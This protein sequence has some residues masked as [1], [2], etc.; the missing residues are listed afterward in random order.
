MSKNKPEKNSSNDF[1]KS[2]AESFRLN[3]F[4]RELWI[5]IIIGTVNGV[6]SSIIVQAISK[7]LDFG[8]FT[9]YA[10]LIGLVIVIFLF[11]IPNL[12]GKLRTNNQIVVAL[13]LGIGIITTVDYKSKTDNSRFPF[14]ETY[15][16]WK[17]NI[18]EGE[19]AVKHLYISG[20]KSIRGNS[21]LAFEVHLQY[22]PENPDNAS[23]IYVDLR[24][25]KR[26][27]EHM[28]DGVN[29]EN[30]TITC[31]VYI[32]DDFPIDRRPEEHPHVIRLFLRDKNQKSYYG[33]PQ[34]I[35]LQGSWLALGLVN[36]NPPPQEIRDEVEIDLN[37]DPSKI[38][39]LGV[40]VSVDTS[41]HINYDGTLY[42]DAVH[43]D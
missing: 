43:W 23:S 22:P 5:N 40:K 25:D 1:P 19:G 14:E 35:D 24:R 8:L 4:K 36:K 42:L 13:V 3:L 33:V 37:F 18:K 27:A 9:R 17:A 2:P 39:Q 16:I 34:N 30:K 31:F 20:E 10:L 21:S 7:P 15:T 28:I 6:L 38:Y 11:V 32:P 12:I 26:W 41:F 29:L